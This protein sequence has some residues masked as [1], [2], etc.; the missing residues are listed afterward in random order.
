MRL[1]VSVNFESQVHAMCHEL[2]AMST[3]QHGMAAYQPVLPVT[4]QGSHRQVQ[5]PAR[6][7]A[8]AA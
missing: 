4:L 3:A 5:Q 2:D 6:L 7:R 1:D 8:L